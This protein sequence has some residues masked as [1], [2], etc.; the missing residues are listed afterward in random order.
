M[1]V[2]FRKYR[3]LL[4]MLVFAVVL[5]VVIVGLFSIDNS[6][7][8]MI[9]EYVEG[10]GW[11]IDASPMEISH[12]TIPDKFDA[13]YQTYNSVQTA[14]GFDLT[15]FKGKNVARYSYRVLNHK[16]SADSEVIVSV[17]VYD[18]RIIAADICSTDSNG[19]MH[20]ITETANIQNE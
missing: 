4:A 15:P 8:R 12:L 7:N 13:V 6:T 3:F 18:S 5:L 17:F 16:R 14:S 20:G 2:V 11:Q 10:L 19:F 9:R 1:I